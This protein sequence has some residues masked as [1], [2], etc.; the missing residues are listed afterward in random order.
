MSVGTTN[1]QD[2]D[3]CFYISGLTQPCLGNK[4]LFQDRRC[5]ANK[6][7]KK[8]MEYNNAILQPTVQRG[9]SWSSAFNCT[10]ELMTL[11]C[12]LEIQSDIL[13]QCLHTLKNPKIPSFMHICMCNA[14]CLGCY[15]INSR[16]QLPSYH[17]KTDSTNF[18]NLARNYHAKAQ[19]H[20]N[21]S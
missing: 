21:N 1:I 19:S 12:S 14:T 9:L 5:I 18:M 10:T 17:L 2:I 8:Y 3:W 15:Q 6:F 4:N 7:T 16:V 11:F 13:H 20:D